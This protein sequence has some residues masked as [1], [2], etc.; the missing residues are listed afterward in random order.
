MG[1][2]NPA[3]ASAG[4]KTARCQTMLWF[5]EFGSYKS[6]EWGNN[7]GKAPVPGYV[8]REFFEES[9]EKKNARK[10]SS[11]TQRR[12]GWRGRGLGGVF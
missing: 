4:G 2:P 1:G 8:K 11:T 7:E 12:H 6:Q 5:L 9:K 10:C 3:N